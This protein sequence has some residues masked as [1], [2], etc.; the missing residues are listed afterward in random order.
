MST[1]S[2]RMD[3]AC[4]TATCSASTTRG[5]RHVDDPSELRLDVFPRKLTADGDAVFGQRLRLWPSQASRTRCVRSST[6]LT[7]PAMISCRLPRSTSSRRIRVMGPTR[8]ACTAARASNSRAAGVV[9]AA[10]AWSSSSGVSGDA[11][12][13]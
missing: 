9:A 8:A 3:L 6:G 10:T 5:H 4:T 2:S 13:S 1:C 12:G 7:R 11:E